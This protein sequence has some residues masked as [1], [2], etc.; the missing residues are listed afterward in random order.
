MHYKSKLLEWVMSQYENPNKQD[1]REIVPNI[2]QT[3]VCCYEIWT[4]MD[5]QIIKN[6]W[7]ISKILP[8]ECDFATKD[9]REKHR[10]Q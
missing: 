3:L 1:L 9:E 10:L 4:E 2:K 7:R 6:S 5:H 8:V